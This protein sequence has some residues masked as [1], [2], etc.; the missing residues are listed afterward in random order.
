MQRRNGYAMYLWTSMAFYMAHPNFAC[1]S[2]TLVDSVDFGE[3]WWM[4]LTESHFVQTGWEKAPWPDAQDD[5]ILAS[6]QIVHITPWGP[7]S[8]HG[9]SCFHRSTR[10]D[11][12]RSCCTV[13][14]R[15]A[16][17]GQLGKNQWWWCLF[18]KLLS[19]NLMLV[20]KCLSHS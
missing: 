3:E 5:L 19:I 4:M 2:S 9:W 13:L 11:S 16:I 12:L 20:T 8:S 18:V 14:L 7:I 15:M 10:K 1:T 6:L 17:A